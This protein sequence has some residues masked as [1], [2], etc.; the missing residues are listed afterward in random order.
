MTSIWELERAG[1][2][3]VE[4]SDYQDE[5]LQKKMAKRWEESCK[6]SKALGA[7]NVDEIRQ[8]Y[9]EK[10]NEIRRMSITGGK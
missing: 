8:H 4:L 9:M 5:E 1:Q 7:S 10:L 2:W 3:L 6:R